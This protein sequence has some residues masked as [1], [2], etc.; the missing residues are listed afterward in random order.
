MRGQGRWREQMFQ[1]RPA[2]ALR[3]IFAT[4]LAVLMAAFTAGCNHLGASSDPEEAADDP[5]EMVELDPSIT[6]LD[7]AAIGVSGPEQIEEAMEALDAQG[8]PRLVREL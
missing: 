5:V 4:T 6:K 1:W 2:T 3:A 7:E 8:G